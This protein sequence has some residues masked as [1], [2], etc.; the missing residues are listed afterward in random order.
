MNTQ[1]SPAADIS[2]NEPERPGIGGKLRRVVHFAAYPLAAATAY[3]SAR[4][5]LRSSLFANFLRT[6]ELPEVK[7]F[8]A[9]LGAIRK[10][11]DPMRKGADEFAR[12]NKKWRTT[13][14]DVF[15]KELGIRDNIVD[16]W[17][18]S[19]PNQKAEAVIF[20]AGA[21]GIV[22]TTLLAIVDSKSMVARVN[23]HEKNKAS[24]VR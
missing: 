17:K 1:L 6:G 21:A 14:D 16:F 23:A 10:A 13:L 8:Q 24:A 3:F 22:L 18:T 15:I 7:A 20:A 11:T 9:E 2:D 4:I 5:S 19:H 12:I